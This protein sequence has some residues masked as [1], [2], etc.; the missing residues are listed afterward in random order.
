MTADSVQGV[1]GRG[2]MTISVAQYQGPVRPHHHTGSCTGPLET[3]RAR[4]VLC[5]LRGIAL[6]EQLL[7]QSGTRE[8]GEL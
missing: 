8:G 2:P 5:L 3:R 1:F 7:D 4:S 6:E